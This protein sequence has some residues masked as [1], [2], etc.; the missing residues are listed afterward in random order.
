[1]LFTAAFAGLHVMGDRGAEIVTPA[2][3]HF[4]GMA[5]RPWLAIT[6]VAG[7]TVLILLLAYLSTLMAQ[8]AD[9]EHLQQM[10]ELVDVAIEGIVVVENGTIAGAN[11]RIAKLCGISQNA[12]IG[13]SV[14]DL[15][16]LDI[17]IG[18][19]REARLGSATGVPVPV[20]VTRRRLRDGK[21]VYALHDL[22]ERQ[23]A[24]RELQRRN[25]LLT[26]R[27]EE[28]RF[29]NLQL[30]TALKHMSQ[31]LCMYDAEERVVLCNERYAMVYGLSPDAVRPGMRRR[32]VIEMRIAAGIWSGTSP[33]DYLDQRTRPITAVGHMIQDMA[34][35]R[36]IA[37]THVPMPGGGWV[38]T[39][40]DITEQRK[41]QSQIA[42]LAR[43]D[44]LTDLPNRLLL[45]EHLGAALGRLRAGD[46]LAV[47][48]LD[49]D[50]FM[51]VND[52]LGQRVGDELLKGVAGRLR[53]IVGETAMLARIGGD[54]FAIV[55]DHAVSPRD[56][57][58]LAAGIIAAMSVPFDLG[59]HL[60]VVL[61]ASIGIAMAPG[62]AGE[63]E[64]L[65]KH[66]NL[67]LSRAKA[68]ERGKYRFFE[69][70]MDARIRARH[71]MEHRLRNALANGELSLAYQ[72][73]LNLKR[74]EIA[75]CEALLRWR[76]P[77]GTMIPP[78][79]FVRLAEE[80]G[81]ILR[82]G[83]WG[84][85][86][87]LEQAA[88]WPRQIRVAVNLS[89]VQFNSRSLAQMVMGALA[90]SGVEPTRLELEITESVLLQDREATLKTL[91]Q[92]R[93]LGVRIA[94]DDFGTGYSSLNYLRSF[95]FDKLKIDRCFIAGIAEGNEESLAIVRAVA[96]LGRSL[97][98]ETTAEGIET[99]QQLQLARKEGFT[100]GQGFWLSVPKGADDIVLEHD[101]CKPTREPRR[102]ARGNGKEPAKLMK[103]ASSKA[104]ADE[105]APAK[106]T[107]RAKPKRSA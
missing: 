102:A 51:E 45:R 76:T 32:D 95:P 31:G 27:E 81:L 88:K 96:K 55:Q 72:P 23:A 12:L 26:E 46:G 62:D 2:S 33:Q 69:R 68:E 16:D 41:A 100:E 34:D 97:G 15:I 80:T 30:D 64:Q 22:S 47:H 77:D 85:R 89:P 35:G 67:A 61:S 1:M 107:P 73:I 54:E 79:E 98:I 66:A 13:K 90:A 106:R 19:T 87:A 25:A 94:L 50:R 103:E 57:I 78:S 104:A 101:L 44:G 91:H 10:H 56:A 6:V 14:V 20:N 86:L 38:C 39:H 21:E 52:A 18:E 99:R 11:G 40:E 8:R 28:L 105:P 7:A 74:N 36:T 49:L 24:E 70:E 82:I 5:W 42:H 83:E 37:L 58:D 84:L 9:R 4:V 93:D 48:C 43:H 92:L 53:R 17:E 29:R 71:T 75:C 60:Q 65:I 3:A 59:D 63:T